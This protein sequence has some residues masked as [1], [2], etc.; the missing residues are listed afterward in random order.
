MNKNYKVERYMTTKDCEGYSVDE[1]RY[2]IVSAETGEILDDAQ[3]YG[4]KTARK[5]YAAYSYKH[6]DRSKDKERAAKEKQIRKWM[7]EN[8]G[9]IDLMDEI[10]FDIAKGS[11]GPNDKMDSKLVKQLLKEQDLHP[12][13]TA[14]DLLRVW[15]KS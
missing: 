10:A 2:R 7:K 8:K 13:F 5:A 12:D 1:A 3:G 15:R 4:Y 6:R 9:F 14:A 11:M